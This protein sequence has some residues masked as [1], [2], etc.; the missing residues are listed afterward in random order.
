LVHED[1]KSTDEIYVMLAGRVAEVFVAETV[2]V[3]REH[4]KTVSLPRY[5]VFLFE[6]W[7]G[8]IVILVLVG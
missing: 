5:R 7:P 8:P 2:S 6:P 1:S 3:F 4:W